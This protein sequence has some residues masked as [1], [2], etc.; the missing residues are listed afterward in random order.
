MDDEYKI[1]ADKKIT[2]G[3]CRKSFEEILDTI[4]VYDVVS[5]FK[6]YKN[7]NEVTDE[8]LRYASKE[9]YEFVN[10]YE[11]VADFPEWLIKLMNKALK[12]EVYYEIAS[13][14][15][16][17]IMKAYPVQYIKSIAGF[18]ELYKMNYVAFASNGKLRLCRNLSDN[19]ICILEY[20][21][22]KVVQCC[23]FNSFD[24]L[25]GL[26]KTIKRR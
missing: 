13:P 21:G 19:T 3:G 23:A 16:S 12:E 20:N 14:S 4:I 8:F 25:K 1:I 10:Q 24:N 11:L 26:I 17:F 7:G 22:K 6:V 5:P 18:Y 9:G 2:R 15:D